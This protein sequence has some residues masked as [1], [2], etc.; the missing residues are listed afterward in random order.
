MNELWQILEAVAQTPR[1]TLIV[2]AASM[3]GFVFSLLA[4]IR[5]GRASKAAMQARDAITVRTLADEIQLACER[6]DQLLNLIAN[7]HIAE[8]ALRAND[9]ASTL[10]EIPYRRSPYLSEAGKNELVN[11]H[12]Q[13]QTIGLL[14]TNLGQPLEGVEKRRIFE[15]CQ[16]CS[17][18]LSSAW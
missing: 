10:S 5:A 9:L 2:G 11:V 1:F 18:T 4:W 14:S 3:F 15:I 8:A 12:T 16:R 7:D 17:A 6:M 13:L